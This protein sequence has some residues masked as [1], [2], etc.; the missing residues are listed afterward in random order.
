MV[1]AFDRNQLDA[2]LNWL[3][4]HT[5]DPVVDAPLGT[6]NEDSPMLPSISSAPSQEI[7]SPQLPIPGLVRFAAS[8][9]PLDFTAAAVLEDFVI[10]SDPSDLP[11][12]VI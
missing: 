12:D 7:S 10:R 8:Q 2:A 4:E 1:N 11:M 6:V 9:N 5:V 3:V